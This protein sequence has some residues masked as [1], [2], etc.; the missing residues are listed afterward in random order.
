MGFIAQ[1]I[2][3]FVQSLFRKGS[4]RPNMQELTSGFQRTSLSNL[5]Y[6]FVVASG[7]P[8]Q[9]KIRRVMECST[10]AYVLHMK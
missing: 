5:F 3:Y 9:E 8:D 1:F 6:D 4:N 7:R 10:V 2:G